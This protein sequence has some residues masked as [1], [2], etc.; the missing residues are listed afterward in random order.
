MNVNVVIEPDGRVVLE[1]VLT[2]AKNTCI[3]IDP[4]HHAGDI[5]ELESCVMCGG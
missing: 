4:A 1:Y 2:A 5:T 3:C